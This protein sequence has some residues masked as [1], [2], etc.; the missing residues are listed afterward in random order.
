MEL[1]PDKDRRLPPRPA[2]NYRPSRSFR[3]S[4]SARS[5][6]EL[7]LPVT[8]PTGASLSGFFRCGFSRLR[9]VDGIP[10]SEECEG[11]ERPD[12][13]SVASIGSLE[14]VGLHL[15]NACLQVFRPVSAG[16]FHVSAGAE[17]IQPAFIDFECWGVRRTIVA[18]LMGRIWAQS[19]ID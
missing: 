7:R 15:M 3:A 5:I 1:D 12:W 13:L 9:V 11:F 4:C 2:Q 16:Q 6:C 19:F 8:R 10:T 18:G 14:A 17:T